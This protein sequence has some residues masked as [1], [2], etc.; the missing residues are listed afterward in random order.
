MPTSKHPN[1]RAAA[2]ALVALPALW[3]GPRAQT[4]APRRLT[5]AQ[6]E[7]PFYPVAIPKDSDHDLLRNGALRYAQGQPTWVDGTVQDAD[8]RPVRGAQVEIWQCDQAGHYHHPGDGGKADA[9]FQG[10]GSVAVDGDGRYRFRTI[11]PVAY[12]GRTPHIHVKVKLAGRELLTTQLYVAGDPHNAR[13][14]LWRNIS[15]DARAALTVAFA[16]GTDGLQAN[17]P[18]VVPA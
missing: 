12:A 3:L 11:R 17:F 6:T 14:F 13:D 10:F 7:G 1:R 18:I 4:P 2:A 15:E 8:G 16:P 5:P 9:A